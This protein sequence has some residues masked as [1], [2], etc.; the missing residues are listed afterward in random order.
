MQHVDALSRQDC[1]LAVH[2]PIFERLERAQRH[3]ERLQAI[4]SL[5]EVGA[6]KNYTLDNGLIF[7]KRGD[8]KLLVVPRGMRDEIIKRAHEIGHF[9]VKKTVL[10]LQEEFSI[11]KIEKNV[12]R[13]IDCCVPC[14]L[15]ANKAGKQ[16][17]MLNPIDK[18]GVPLHTWHID[19]IGEL[20]STNKNYK[21]LLVVIDAL[22]KFTWL[23]TTKT[24]GV[25]E[26]IKKI[27]I[28][29]QHYGNPSR[30]IA[31]KGFKSDSFNALC[32]ENN[33]LCHY[34]TTGLPRGNGQVERIHRVLKAVFTKYSTEQP[35]TWFKYVTRVQQAI[36]GTHH[37][38]ISTSPFELL[39]GVKL[40]S[41]EDL[42]IIRLLDDAARDD[43][44]N[45][46]SALRAAAIKQIDKVQQENRRDY[47]RNRKP[48]TKYRLNDIVAIKRTQFGPG[49]KLAIK[50]LGPY[51]VIKLKKND[52]YRVERI[53]DGEGPGVTTTGADLMKPW[54]GFADDLEP[55]DFSDE[56]DQDAEAAES[57]RDENVDHDGNDGS[58]DE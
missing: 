11:E 22:T 47:N 43:F 31:D 3:D 15:G 53:G 39:F 57:G 12:Q 26:V 54:T 52:R 21:Y 42:E 34:I 14:I 17:G 27:N 23:F 1:V 18:E 2:D 38:S 36:N 48:A 35:R 55:D 46:R 25:D 13:V 7:E 10:K 50:F 45:A 37:R 40:K 33:I 56:E 5:L 44:V 9:A 58:D 6:D 32:E 19:H 8:K 30:I 4:R 20:P 29:Q 49:L 16:E 41:P 24:K 51:K 28:L